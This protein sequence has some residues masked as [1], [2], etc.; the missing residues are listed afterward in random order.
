AVWQ[1]MSKTTVED[2]DVNRCMGMY[3]GHDIQ[4]VEFT[5][6][7]F[8]KY[9][10]LT[11]HC[12]DFTFSMLKHGVITSF[13]KATDRDKGK[14]KCRYIENVPKV[15]GFDLTI[16]FAFKCGCA[17]SGGFNKQIITKIDLPWRFNFL[18]VPH[19][20]QLQWGIMWDKALESAMVFEHMETF[21]ALPT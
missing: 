9:H 8:N 7:C 16:D 11:L 10:F 12:L 19:L 18:K 6:V 4:V 13:F 3:F 21:E 1:H 20:N 2:I 17:N 14:L 5:L 15:C